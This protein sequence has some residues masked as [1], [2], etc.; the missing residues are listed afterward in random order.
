MGLFLL[1]A[2]LTVGGQKRIIQISCLIIC[3]LAALQSHVVQRHVER[4]RVG[5]SFKACRRILAQTHVHQ[6]IKYETFK[7]HTLH[8][9]CFLY[10][11]GLSVRAALH[12]PPFILLCLSHCSHPRWFISAQIRNTEQF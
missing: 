8:V 12:L 3:I 5:N 11:L 10:G 6:Y 4:A 1:Q 9:L 7:S 2:Y